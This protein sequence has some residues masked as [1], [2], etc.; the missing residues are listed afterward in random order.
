MGYLTPVQRDALVQRQQETGVPL[1]QLLV[2]MGLLDFE[3]VKEALDEYHAS[4][5]GSPGAPPGRAR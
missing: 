3:V 2:E 1:G 4:R 5:G